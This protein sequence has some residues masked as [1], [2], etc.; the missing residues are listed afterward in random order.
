MGRRPTPAP[1]EDRGGSIRLS[2]GGLS[3]GAALF[4]PTFPRARVTWTDGTSSLEVETVIDRVGRRRSA[5]GDAGPLPPGCGSALLHHEAELER[6]GVSRTDLTERLRDADVHVEGQ[7]ATAAVLD[8][9]PW[10]DEWAATVPVSDRY[11]LVLRG[12]GVEPDGLA[13]ARRTL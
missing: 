1:P 11:H 9:R 2:G 7:P 6:A 3:R 5:R 10:V 12:S 8:L 4:S 13:L